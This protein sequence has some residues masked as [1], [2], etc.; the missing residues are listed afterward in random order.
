M[1]ILSSTLVRG[2]EVLR[3][4]WVG[5]DTDRR[6]L[7]QWD[8]G[9]GEPVPALLAESAIEI[10]ADAPEEPQPVL[11]LFCADCGA[12]PVLIARVRE[13]L[14]LAERP[15]HIE[16]EARESVSLRCGTASVELD[17]QGGVKVRG[18]TIL[19]RARG[20]HRLKGGAIHIN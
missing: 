1:S 19:S 11:L 20:T 10:G 7:V 18:K 8:G 13:S 9:P 2:A 15:A 14:A 6:P 12:T 5:L 4:E 17:R 16:L 3:G